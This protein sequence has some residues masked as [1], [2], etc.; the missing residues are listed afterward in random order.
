MYK[1]L[2]ID[3]NEDIQY[4][5][6]EYLV[7]KGYA[8]DTAFTGA[9]A[10]T[11]LNT[12]TYDCIL[13]DVL[14]PDFNGFAICEAARRKIKTPIIF[15]S[16]MDGEDDRIRGLLSGGDDYICKP[17]SLKELG[18]RVYAQIRRTRMEEGGE[19]EAP[20]TSVLFDKALRTV[21]VG[22]TNI[23]LT[24]REYKVLT[25]LMEQ[26]GKVFSAD[27][28]IREVWADNAG[29]DAANLR[30][31]IQRIRAK[32]GSDPAVGYIE[33]D[34]G[35]GYRYLAPRIGRSESW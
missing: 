10:V 28:I 8:A 32:M 1:L 14:L 3:D 24:G 31:H 23:I 34:F 17:Y 21:N 33:N 25:L 16:C 15:L 35:N 30:I 4:A 26:P 13:L 22:G 18:A 11:L 7:E 2:L 19:D 5:N 20:P 6:R 9:E 27:E 29:V 12:R